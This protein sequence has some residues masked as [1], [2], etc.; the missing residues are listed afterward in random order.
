M[1][2]S[3]SDFLDQLEEDCLGHPALSHSYLEG[4]SEGKVDRATI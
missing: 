4:F 2:L 1:V 3:A